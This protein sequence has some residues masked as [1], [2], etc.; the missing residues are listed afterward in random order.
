MAY[1]LKLDDWQ[2]SQLIKGAP[3][4]SPRMRSS[5]VI[6]IE[7]NDAFT[8]IARGGGRTLADVRLLARP[9]PFLELPAII[10]HRLIGHAL[11]TFRLG[12]RL[13]PKTGAAILSALE[14]LHPDLA[15]Y[16]K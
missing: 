10:P 2:Y 12:G 15:P 1:V 5:E 3:V 4:P 14:H 13:P 7:R 8:H 9:I 6:L 11:H 16:V